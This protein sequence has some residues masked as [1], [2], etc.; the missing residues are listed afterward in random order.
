MSIQALTA[1]FEIVA[2]PKLE[3]KIE[4]QTTER[5]SVKR[6]DRAPSTEPSRSAS[7]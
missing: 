1:P 2:V 5:H 3:G 7:H 6:H 4:F